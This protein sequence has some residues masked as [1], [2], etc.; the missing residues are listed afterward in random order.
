MK[1]LIRR[2][3]STIAARVVYP[4]RA[5]STIAAR[6]VYP[7]RPPADKESGR[8]I[9]DQL[10]GKMYHIPPEVYCGAQ[11]DLHDAEQTHEISVG[12]GRFL[13]APAS[14]ERRRVATTK[15]ITTKALG[16]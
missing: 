13:P 10:F 12:N 2:A 5:T 7:I 8:V 3:S 14:L 15:E 4:I 16:I 1:R 9:D 6:V 11:S